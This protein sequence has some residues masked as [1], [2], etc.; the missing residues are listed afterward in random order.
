MSI[1][2]TRHLM[3]MDDLTD[4]DITTILDHADLHIAANAAGPAAKKHGALRGQTVVNLFLEPSTR[5]RTSF[6]IAGK[7]LVPTWSIFLAQPPQL[8]RASRSSIPLR[9]WTPWTPTW[10]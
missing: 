9:P 7:R 4:E 2:S 6:E 3:T 1:L 10:W 5:T 8:R